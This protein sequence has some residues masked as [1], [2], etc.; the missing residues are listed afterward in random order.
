MSGMERRDFLKLGGIG[1]AGLAVGGFN[2]PLFTPRRAFASETAWKFGVLADTQ[3]RTG[4]NAGGEPA[5]CAVT[6]IDA[7]NQQ[8]IQHD[9]KFVIQVGD[10]ID[11]ETAD[12]TPTGARSLPTRAAHA[13][14]L[15]SAGIG[16]F[17][18]RGNHESSQVAALE[19]P[20]LFP[21]TQGDGPNLHGAK[22]FTYP[23]DSLRGLSYS[24]DYENVRCVLVDQ[25]VRANGS[26]YDGTTSYNNNAVD[27]VA[28][29]D[30]MLQS[31]PQDSHAFVF[32]HKNLIG[33]NHKD[34]LFGANLAANPGPRDQFIAS[35]YANG[36]RYHMS[37]HDH[38]HHRSIVKTGDG[39]SSIGQ[40]IC[41]SNSYK[42]YIPQIG[43]DGR[44]TPLGQEIFTIGYYI[45]TVDGPRVTVDFYSSSHGQNY[46]DFD[47]V[48]PPA[49]FAFYLR[50]T[51]GYSLNGKQFQVAHGESYASIEDTYEGTTARILGGTNGNTETDYVTRPL[52]K[53]VNTGW[54]PDSGDTLASHVL[55]LW[56]MADNLS[57]W[58]D[59]AR[60]LD[61]VGLLPNAAESKKGDTYTL[62]MSYDD[63][64]VRPIHLG[65]GG[66]G[67][68]TTDANGNWINA[69]D[70]NFGGT[71]KF[72]VGPWDPRYELGTYGVDPSGKTAWAV[73]NH[74]G[75]FVV[76]RNIEPVP[77]HR[78]Q[79]S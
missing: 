43:D 67:I 61:L 25:F 7:L 20:I 70:G 30:S 39:S 74:E 18:V 48:T 31:K 1:L 50:E 52:A 57:L 79:E 32:S 35:L 10:L 55:T 41:S 40:L 42:F 33:Q 73:L 45:F 15:Y 6:I 29:V 54:T 76:A 46:G 44:E 47:L 51:F 8:F 11:K 72:V 37:G 19:I 16:F 53:T 64:K 75:D 34:V 26:N 28:W 66:F 9:V 36:V 62:A 5:S 68:A 78:E 12:G 13:E 17:P 22:H 27:Q 4:L 23:F 63:K 49:S 2:L 14:A 58:D 65:N 38:M 24:F 60:G 21:Q 69:V 3:W 59:P 77:G 71:K 56:G